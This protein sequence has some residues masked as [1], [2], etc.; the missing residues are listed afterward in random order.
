LKRELIF[1]KFQHSWLTIFQKFE[2]KKKQNAIHVLWYWI[3]S[4]PSLNMQSCIT[5]SA[6]MQHA[7]REQM[8]TYQGAPEFT[9]ACITQFFTSHQTNKPSSYCASTQY[10]EA[11]VNIGLALLKRK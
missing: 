4:H 8:D 9:T 1:W 6:M 2:I 10:F 7:R 3:C 11:M 5:D